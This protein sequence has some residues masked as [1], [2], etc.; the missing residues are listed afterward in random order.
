MI[1]IT[2]VEAESI[3]KT[4]IYAVMVVGKSTPSKTYNDFTE[5][6]QEAIRLTSIEKRT[7]YVLRAVS[8]YELNDVKKTTL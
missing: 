8:M 3:Q 6:E 5:A 1:D 7:A 2:T 4:E